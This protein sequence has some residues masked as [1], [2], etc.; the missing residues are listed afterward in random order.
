MGSLLQ[1]RLVHLVTADHSEFHISS[2]FFAATKREAAISRLE[3]F[4]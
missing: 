2:F 3:W 4:R 1:V